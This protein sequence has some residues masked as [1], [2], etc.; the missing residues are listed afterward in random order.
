MLPACDIGAIAPLAVQVRGE[1]FGLQVNDLLKRL[2]LAP[3]AYG[4]SQTFENVLDELAHSLS[5]E[6]T[7]CGVDL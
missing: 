6:V 4:D 5:G 2:L 3:V 1:E 7:R